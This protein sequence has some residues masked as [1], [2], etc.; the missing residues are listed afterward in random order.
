MCPPRGAARSRARGSACPFAHLPKR[1]PDGKEL[2]GL[3]R[4]LE[5]SLREGGEGR[6]IPGFRV[7]LRPA[8]PHD[9]IAATLQACAREGGEGHGRAG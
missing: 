7:N 8:L 1:V 6:G 5:V 4:R 9:G 2:R 3:G